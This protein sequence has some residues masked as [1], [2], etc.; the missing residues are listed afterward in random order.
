MSVV[1]FLVSVLS[2]SHS[3]VLECVC[4][5]FVVSF[6]FSS[7]QRRRLRGTLKPVDLVAGTPLSFY[8]V[9]KDN[10]GNYVPRRGGIRDLPRNPDI[11]TRLVQRSPPSI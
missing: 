5:N 7:C 1:L 8:V 4:T 6:A 11:L 3:I 2:Y 9:A 10:K